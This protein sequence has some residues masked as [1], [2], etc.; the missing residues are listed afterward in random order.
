MNVSNDFL[1]YWM[2]ANARANQAT[3]AAAVSALTIAGQAPFTGSFQLTNQ[4]FLP[5]FT[6]TSSALPVASFPQFASKA[7]HVVSGG[8]NAVGVSTKDTLLWGFGLENIADR[9]T[10]ATLIRQGLGSLG[11]D[12]YTQTTGGVSGSGAGHAGAHARRQPVVRELHPGRDED[13][14]LVDD[15]HRRLLGG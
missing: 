13:V 12:P 2:G 8:T 1:Q 6:P 3:T 11:V 14:H 10:R 5:R 9:A 7:T 4:A 15:R